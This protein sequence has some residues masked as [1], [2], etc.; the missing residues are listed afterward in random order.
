MNQALAQNL[1]DIS[2]EELDKQIRIEMQARDNIGHLHLL[3][4][5]RL[6]RNEVISGASRRLMLLKQAADLNIM[7]DYETWKQGTWESFYEY[8]K[9]RKA[10]YERRGFD[11]EADVLVVKGY[12]T[13]ESWCNIVRHF[14]DRHGWSMELLS[15]VTKRKLEVVGGTCNAWDALH[16]GQADPELMNL[17]FDNSVSSDDILTMYAKLKKKDGVNVEIDA[18]HLDEMP[19]EEERDGDERTD[20]E[21]D[22]SSDDDDDDGGDEMRVVLDT[23]DGKLTA[24]VKHGKSEVPMTLGKLDVRNDDKREIIVNLC[25]TWRVILQ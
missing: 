18:P 16:D 1:G 14:V 20:Y 7:R 25:Q 23:E 3:V 6:G 10:E 22:T 11:S 9:D 12:S 21:R 4:E 17:L 8:L 2:P 15:T 19:D 24:W 5:E 13:T